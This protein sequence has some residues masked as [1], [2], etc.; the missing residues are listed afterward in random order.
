MFQMQDVLIPGRF[1]CFILQ[2]LLT[3]SICFSYDDFINTTTTKYDSRVFY[4]YLAIFLAFELVE[5]IILLTGYTLF[6][7]LLSIIQ[8]LLHSISVLLLDWFV[9]DVW[10]TSK[11]VAPFVIGGVIPFVFEIIDLIIICS[12]NRKITKIN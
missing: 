6:S 10:K 7:N 3:I 12:S 4:A 9:R 8:M 5:F 1:C 11:I 2:V